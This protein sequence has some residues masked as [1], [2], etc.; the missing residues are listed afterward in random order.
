MVAGL[1]WLALNV[2]VR[3]RGTEGPRKDWRRR[4]QQRGAGGSS[5]PSSGEGSAPYKEGRWREK[6]RAPVVEHAWEMLCGSIIQQVS[7]GMTRPLDLE[8]DIEP[9]GGRHT[10]RRKHMFTEIVAVRR[11]RQPALVRLCCIATVIA[12]AG[13]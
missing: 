5:Q 8:M 6:V 2:D 10:A 7:Y 1:R 11:L 12:D 3:Y 13:E 9:I 4:K